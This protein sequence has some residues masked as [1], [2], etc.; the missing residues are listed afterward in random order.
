MPL[1]QGTDVAERRVLGC[2][3]SSLPPLTH[4]SAKINNYSMSSRLICYG[5]IAYEVCNI[6]KVFSQIYF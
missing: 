3:W 4:P 2:L 5:P 6:E 1:M